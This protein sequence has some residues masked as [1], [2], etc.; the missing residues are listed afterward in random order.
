MENKTIVIE[1]AKSSKDFHG[2]IINDN[3]IELHIPQGLDCSEELTKK[4]RKII[5]KFL[6]SLNISNAKREKEIHDSVEKDEGEVWAIESYLWIMKDF[7]SNG[8][9]YPHEKVYKNNAPGKIDWKKTLQHTPLLSRKGFV[10]TD[11]VTS[12]TV[13]SNSEIT[14]IYKYCLKIA[15]D[16]LGWLYN[17]NVNIENYSHLP[18]VNMRHIVQSELRQ[19]FD[20]IKKKRFDVM[21][22]ILNDVDDNT[23]RQKR[24]TCGRNNFHYIFE[25]MI[26]S[27]FGG[28][29]DK[30]L[31]QYFAHGVWHM[32]GQ[33]KLSSSLKPDTVCIKDS[34]QE[35]RTYILDSK[36]YGEDKSEEDNNQESSKVRSNMPSS[37]S[38][39]KQITYAEH[40]KN[41]VDAKDNKDNPNKA[42][43]IRNVF[44]LPCKSGDL[45]Q[46]ESNPMDYIG[47]ATALWRDKDKSDYDYIL[48]YQIS[49]NYVYENYKKHPNVDWFF[50]QVEKNLKKV[51]EEDSNNA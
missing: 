15:L 34:K 14:K 6:L 20:D 2:I 11:M 22:N 38:I 18:I 48:A 8:Y 19:T 12:S 23:M 33:D 25:R 42:Y 9:Y 28:I 44:I 32:A 1:E 5:L 41:V 17:K 16:R 3:K 26:N 50:N 4:D 7:F 49:L 39:Q 36:C 29:N 31:Q 40:A 13:P 47:Y 21:L 24:H 30:Q 37:D 27:L 46:A 45:K 43:Y 35:R 10:F 51:I